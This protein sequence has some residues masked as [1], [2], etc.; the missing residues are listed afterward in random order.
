MPH[1]YSRFICYPDEVSKIKSI[2]FGDNDK[3]LFQ[4]ID[5]WIVN[6]SD[7]KDIEEQ[8]YCEFPNGTIYC[9]II[10]I[11]DI[12]KGQE[13]YPDISWSDGLTYVDYKE[14][15]RIEDVSDSKE[16][17]WAAKHVESQFY[18]NP[19]HKIIYKIAT[20]TA[21]KSITMFGGIKEENR[22]YMPLAQLYQVGVFEGIH[23]DSVGPQY[24]QN[25]TY[26]GWIAE[27]YYWI[28]KQ[29]L[30]GQDNEFNI[31]RS[32]CFCQALTSI[33]SKATR[34]GIGILCLILQMGL[35]YICIHKI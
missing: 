12:M 24:H 2:T 9:E 32:L 20:S 27:R 10:A 19:E 15:I 17:I 7:V 29:C 23:R 25:I 34:L 11:E 3:I 31:F 35:R 1:I 4:E 33:P 14:C 26:Q 13:S 28:S 18:H 8:K 30:Y 21:I 6:K 5:N 16:C 22:K